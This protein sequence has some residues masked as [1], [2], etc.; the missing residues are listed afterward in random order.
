MKSHRSYTA[1][2]LVEL[3][4]AATLK[5]RQ[6]DHAA[7]K[8]LLHEALERL[9]DIYECT[10]SQ[11]KQDLPPVCYQA[12][13][14]RSRISH[15]TERKVCTEKKC[16]DKPKTI[17]SNIGVLYSVRMMEQEGVYYDS[18]VPSDSILTFYDRAFIFVNY[19][20]IDFQ[21]PENKSNLSAMILYN[22]ALSHHSQGIRQGSTIELGK[23]LQFYRLAHCV[24]EKV[25]DVV[26][27]EVHLLIL[28]GL[29]NNMGHIHAN[30][31]NLEQ[32]SRCIEWLQRAISSRHSGVLGDADYRFFYTHLK[33]IPVGHIEF[34]PAA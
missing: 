34:A 11:I 28:M 18:A 16:L 7:A 3:N 30:C 19:S 12:P 9:H 6:R 24:L 5:I 15:S 1:Q 17:P 10:S 33:V 21:L 13:K 20:D 22:L 2:E 8:T 32:T 26:G 31:Y 4:N 29:L 23:A 25:K 14:K 27:L